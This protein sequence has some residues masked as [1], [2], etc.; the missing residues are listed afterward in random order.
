M[1]LLEKRE[2]NQNFKAVDNYT[3]HENAIQMKFDGSHN[4]DD[5]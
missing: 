5:T 2:A 1:R 3:M 4:V